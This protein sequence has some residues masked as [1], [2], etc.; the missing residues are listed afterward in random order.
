MPGSGILNT[1]AFLQLTASARGKQ[2]CT[3]SVQRRR[4]I[5]VS[6]L[7]RCLREE[8]EIQSKPVT[9]IMA[10]IVA[11]TAILLGQRK[12]AVGDIK[13]ALLLMDERLLTPELLRQLLAYAPDA[14]EVLYMHIIPFLLV[15]SHTNICSQALFVFRCRWS[16]MTRI[17]GY[18]RT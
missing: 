5:S 6:C 3:L 7:V 18:W 2:R 17:E 4:T 10:S 14:N 9:F 11:F 13:Q 12:M 15:S 8:G 1:P 16:G